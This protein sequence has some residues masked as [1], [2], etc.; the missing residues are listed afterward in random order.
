MSGNTIFVSNIEYSVGGAELA[1]AFEQFGEIKGARIVTET[2]RGAELSKGIGFVDFAN[3]RAADDAI[4]FRGTISIKERPLRVQRCRRPRVDTTN[5]IFVVGFPDDT[6][7]EELMRAFRIYEPISARIIQPRGETE[8]AYGFVEF[9]NDEDMEDCLY[10]R[11]KPLVRGRE[12]ICRMADAPRRRTIQTR[13]PP[14]RVSRR[15]YH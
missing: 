13:R 12:I 1:A 15:R 11:T 6:E 8:R 14:P 3:A 2:I 7:S 4:N 5:T 9:S 10:S